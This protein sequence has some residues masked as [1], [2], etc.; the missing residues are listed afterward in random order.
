MSVTGI[1]VLQSH[2]ACTGNDHV[3]VYF[4]PDTCKDDFHVHHVHQE[5]G[6]ETPASEHDCHECA[7]HTNDCGCNNVIVSLYK[8][9]NEVIKDNGRTETKMPLQSL[10]FAIM[11]QLLTVISDIPPEEQFFYEEPPVTESAFDVLIRIHQLKISF[12]A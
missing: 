10:Q 6:E 7:N 9:K 11:A 5:G 4:Q 3:S 1:V 8:L 2:C 12:I